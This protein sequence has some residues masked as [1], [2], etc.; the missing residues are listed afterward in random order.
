MHDYAIPLVAERQRDLARSRR[1]RSTALVAALALVLSAAG[2]V[3]AASG[4]TAD[5]PTGDAVSV[6]R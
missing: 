2:G 4:V 6:V 5:S 1:R 3:A